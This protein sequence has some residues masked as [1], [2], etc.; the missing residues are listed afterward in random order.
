MTSEGKPLDFEEADP[1]KDQFGVAQVEQFTWKGLLDFTTCTECGRCQSQCPAWNTGKPLS[2]K[3]LDP[4]PARP[5]VRQG[6]VPAGRRRQGPDRRG[7]GHPGAARQGRRARPRR[8]RPAADRR[9]RG[10]RRHRPGRAVVLHHLRRLRRAVPGRHRARRPH[11]RHAP[12]PGAD[13]V[14]LPVRGRRDAAQPGEQGQPVGRAAEHPRGLDQGAGLR[15]APGRRG[16]GLRV[17]VL[18][19][20]RRCV[21]GPGQE[22]HPGGRHPA[23]RGGRLLRHPRRG[24]DLHR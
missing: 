11:R 12:L 6:A 24:R 10:R 22:D 21:R 1:E 19:R 15:G 14:E 7:E 16:R 9:R 23:A 5:R 20:L 4:Q 18:G 8:G 2:P 17:P 13:R 3:L